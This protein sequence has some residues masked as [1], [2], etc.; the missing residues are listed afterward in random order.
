MGSE[1]SC[2]LCQHSGE[3]TTETATD[4]GAKAEL[5]VPDF[6][7]DN[8]EIRDCRVSSTDV[9]VGDTVTFS[10][11]IFSSNFQEGR[12]TVVW[13][14][15]DTSESSWNNPMEAIV[16]RPQREETADASYTIT[17]D[18]LQKSSGGQLEVIPRLET[19]KARSLEASGMVRPR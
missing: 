3:S 18:D 8:V 9:E 12:A 13:Y 19:V 6:D 10:M 14:L 5:D 7:P 2:S 17:R 4:G 15:G 1:D 16:L 11:D